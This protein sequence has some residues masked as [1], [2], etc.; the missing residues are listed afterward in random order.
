MR[1]VPPNL[2]VLTNFKDDLGD[3][4]NGHTTFEMGPDMIK[5]NVK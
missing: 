3:F 2:F 4:C 5:R 1:G